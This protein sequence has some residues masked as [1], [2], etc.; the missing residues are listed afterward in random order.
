MTLQI[1]IPSAQTQA[2]AQPFVAAKTLDYFDR[3]FG[4]KVANW[5]DAI[6]ASRELTPEELGDFYRE[7]TRYTL[8]NHAPVSGSSRNTV[9]GT[10]NM[11]QRSTLAQRRK[12]AGTRHFAEGPHVDGG[13]YGREDQGEQEEVFITETPA[14]D[15][16]PL[17]DE[18]TDNISNTEG[19][20]VADA[21][22][23]RSLTSRLERQRRELEATAREYQR[24]TAG[25]R[26]VADEYA[27]GPTA[28]EVNPTVPVSSAEELTG[29][30]FTS[31]DPDKALETQPGGDEGTSLPHESSL[32]AFQTFDRWLTA[33][34]GKSSRYH[35][36][37]NIRT[38]A[39]QFA[40]HNKIP[41][42]AMFPALGIV[43]RE[44]R[45]N[46]A[47][48]KR[49]AAKVRK[50]AVDLET[51]APDERISV[52]EP[53]LHTDADSQAS[54]FDEDG[55]GNNAGDDIADPDLGT[56]Q[57]FAP[58]E[59]PKR[60]SRKADGILA[61]RTA[62]AMIAAGL[63]ENTRERKYALAAEYSKMNRGLILDRC[64]MAEKFAMVRQADRQALQQKVASGS[65]RGTAP[66]PPGFTQGGA[67]SPRTASRRVAAN[68]PINDGL[69][70]S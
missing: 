42:Q 46:E 12:T 11:P 36:E 57:N 38:A 1:P 64:H 51:A 30:H 59:A 61:I 21:E 60:E 37:K 33:S 70:F 45:K 67:T 23:A 17:P 29:D 25:R 15:S 20:L 48:A 40:A 50:K 32:K 9:K 47:A 28:E 65:T 10:A 16:T 69:L 22:Y 68:D 13:P 55:F 14:P 6:E 56:G 49:K 8:E 52:P 41:V 34:T 63:E 19:N 27:G 54:Q 39:R 35:T 4:R 26:K 5:R 24:V 2:P 66:L 53:V 62:E 58:G 44:A 18:D 7:A 3:Y 31:A 43:L